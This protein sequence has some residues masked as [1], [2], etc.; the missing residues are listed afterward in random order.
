MGFMYNRSIEDLD[1][2]VLKLVWMD[3]N[4]NMA[5]GEGSSK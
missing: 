2:H 4:T 5:S 1:G 3:M